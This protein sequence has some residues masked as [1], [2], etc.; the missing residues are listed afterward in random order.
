MSQQHDPECCEQLRAFTGYN[1]LLQTAYYAVPFSRSAEG[2]QKPS[3]ATAWNIWP[4]DVFK[5]GSWQ[6]EGLGLC[7][8]L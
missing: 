8:D 1:L 3:S 7:F 6:G 4:V 5:F 2:K